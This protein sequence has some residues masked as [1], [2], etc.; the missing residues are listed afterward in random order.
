[1]RSALLLA[2]V[3]FACSE[4]PTAS[5]RPVTGASLATVGPV[6]GGSGS[7]EFLW[8]KGSGSIAMGPSTGRVCFLTQVGGRFS[9]TST[10]VA[11]VQSFG[12]WYLTG[13]TPNNGTS[14]V[15]ARARC[16]TV[17][18][19]T[20]EQQLISAEEEEYKPLTG[21]MC[22]LTRVGGRID[23]EFDGVEIF[24]ETTNNT[25]TLW[26]KATANDDVIAGA[27]CML[28]PTTLVDMPTWISP[29]G[30]TASSATPTDFCMLAAVKGEFTSTN[31]WVY[32]SKGVTR[33]S[34]LGGSGPRIA[35]KAYCFH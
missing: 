13:A 11:T 6:P 14:A 26:T 1:M 9:S 8:T 23:T 16:V 5:D 29:A 10:W 35:G 22:G 4:A 34:L 32:V 21:Q 18:N 27:R 25:W 28:T 33:W 3:L 31:D 17:G 2:V 12:Q 20:A 24:H 15:N 7:G 19:Y 30:Y